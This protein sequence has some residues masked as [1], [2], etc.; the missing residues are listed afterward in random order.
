M[1]FETYLIINLVV[2]I[3]FI[4]TFVNILKELLEEFPT[5]DT[6]IAKL[7]YFVIILITAGPVLILAALRTL[8]KSE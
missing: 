3:F 7:L 4:N 2:I 8:L 1:S 5:L 6:E